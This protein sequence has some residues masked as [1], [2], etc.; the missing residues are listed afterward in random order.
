MMNNLLIEI[1]EQKLTPPPHSYILFKND[2][3]DVYFI[4]ND[5]SIHTIV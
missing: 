4:L 2:H 5:V 3:D 1:M